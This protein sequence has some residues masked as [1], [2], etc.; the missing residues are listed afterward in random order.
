MGIFSQRIDLTGMKFGNWLVV[1]AFESKIKPLKWECICDCGKTKIIVGR[2]LKNG[3]SKSC[4]CLRDAINSNKKWKGFEEISGTYFGSLE[5]GAKKRNIKFSITID[6]VWSIFL[7]QNRKCALSGIDIHFAKNIK[8]DGRGTASLD[9]INSTLGYVENNVQWVHKDLNYM[10]Q[11][12]CENY[13]FD[14]CKKVYETRCKQTNFGL[15]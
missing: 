12:L 4:G 14:L 2:S 10:K 9:R 13:F 7:K 5:Q 1:K 8:K 3:S 15:D 6:Y 11:E